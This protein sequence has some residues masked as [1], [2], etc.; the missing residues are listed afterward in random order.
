MLESLIK[1][2][3]LFHKV[4]HKI[5]I[6]CLPTP[7]E[8]MQVLRVKERLRFDQKQHNS[9]Y[10]FITVLYNSLETKEQ[11]SEIQFQLTKHIYI[12]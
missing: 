12:N 8:I 2:K 11:S 6:S 9:V 5:S 7:V 1:L 10:L 4:N 3:S